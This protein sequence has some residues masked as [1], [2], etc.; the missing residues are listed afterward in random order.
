MDTQTLFAILNLVGAPTVVGYFVVQV[1]RKYRGRQV[2]AEHN[3]ITNSA[4]A[5]L[6]VRQADYIEV[7]RAKIIELNGEPPSWPRG[8]TPKKQ[9]K[10]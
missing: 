6:V 4:N 10:A 2:R 8:L 5:I 7:L 1:I 9:P 3:Q